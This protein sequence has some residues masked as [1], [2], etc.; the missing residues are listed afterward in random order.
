MYERIW[1]L[2]EKLGISMSEI[3]RRAGLGK[4]TISKW[5]TLKNPGNDNVKKV[6]DVLGVSVDY[7][8]TG[9]EYENPLFS[10]ENAILGSKILT[11]ERMMDSLSK[12]YA[13]SAE[14]QEDIIDLINMYFT[15]EKGG[16]ENG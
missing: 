5:K 11:D 3:E 10:S 6:A 9:K 14:R 15:K 13:L 1:E 12:F 16:K 2:K 8:L 4:G 7:L